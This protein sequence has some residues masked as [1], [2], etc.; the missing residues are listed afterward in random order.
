MMASGKTLKI[1][2]NKPVITTSR[3]AVFN[4]LKKDNVAFG[5]NLISLSLNKVSKAF[6]IRDTSNKN[7]RPNISENESNLFKRNFSCRN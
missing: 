2:A 6:T 3:I 5:K 7:P 4:K 1:T